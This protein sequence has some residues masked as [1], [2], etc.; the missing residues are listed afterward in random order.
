MSNIFD[1]TLLNDI[2][3]I[4]NRANAKYENLLEMVDEQSDPFHK[5]LC[6]H[7]ADTQLYLSTACY[8]LRLTG[9]T[10]NKVVAVVEKLP[11]E[12]VLNGLRSELDELRL[13][14]V[15]VL[16][17]LKQKLDAAELRERRAAEMDGYG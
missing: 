16:T 10:L 12:N 1:D 11:T 13:K 14:A 2:K 17:E 7:L 4:Q 15:P 6:A 9:E 5:W 8:S 3:V